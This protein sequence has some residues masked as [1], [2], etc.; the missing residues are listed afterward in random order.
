MGLGITPG[1]GRAGSICVALC[2]PDRRASC[3][4]TQRT[5]RRAHSRRC[6][7]S[8]PCR[9]CQVC[10]SWQARSAE[11]AVDIVVSRAVDVLR[12]AVRTIDRGEE[13]CP[14]CMRYRRTQTAHHRTDPSS[15]SCARG[16]CSRRLPGSQ[17]R[18][19]R[20]DESIER[21]RR[22][23]STW[24]RCAASFTRRITA[25]RDA[26][27]STSWRSR[28]GSCAMQT[29]GNSTFWGEA[30]VSRA[31]GSKARGHAIDKRSCLREENCRC[32]ASQ[33]STR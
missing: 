18:G 30:T 1:W 6:R 20:Y 14:T 28:R 29:A 12:F 22:Y 4:A 9:P 16:V 33:A 2:G 32:A 13:G 3:P 31:G 8:Q 19:W 5:C 24:A 10:R 11:V 17:R 7:A 15:N 23:W 27:T 21:C 25:E 26:P